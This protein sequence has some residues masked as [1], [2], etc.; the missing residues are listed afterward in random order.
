MV[1]PH[2]LKPNL[3]CLPNLVQVERL[4]AASLR[5]FLIEV[6]LSL[7]A[8]GKVLFSLCTTAVSALT[9]RHDVIPHLT[10]MHEL[11]QVVT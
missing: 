2:Q 5:G 7:A 8:H 1:R 3:T 9:Q 10:E 6:S 4:L 11:I